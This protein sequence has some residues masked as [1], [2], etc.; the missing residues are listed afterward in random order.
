M[1]Y[2]HA[3]LIFDGLFFFHCFAHHTVECFLLFND[4]IDNYHLFFND[5]IENCHLLFSDLNF[6][7]HFEIHNEIKNWWKTW[8]FDAKR[9]RVNLKMIILNRNWCIKYEMSKTDCIY[10]EWRKNNW[11]I[12]DEK[13]QKYFICIMNMN[14]NSDVLMT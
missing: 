14:F 3:L 1:H 13:F 12:K 4:R 9:R 10:E 11:L 6:D 7:W 2:F 5:R 8:I